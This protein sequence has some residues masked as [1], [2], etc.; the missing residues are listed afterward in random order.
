MHTRMHMHIMHITDSSSKG[1][2]EMFP[3]FRHKFAPAPCTHASMA[4][5]KFQTEQPRFRP[6]TARSK[7]WPAIVNV[8]ERETSKLDISVQKN[9]F[10]CTFW[11][12]IS[13][14]LEG[15]CV[16]EACIS[17]RLR[18]VRCC[19]ESP[20]QCWWSRRWATRFRVSQSCHPK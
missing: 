12:W 6:P 3:L 7:F 11:E 17:K 10:I 2:Y 1:V 16:V 13:D 15:S 20:R 9:N 8:W 4:P 19:L 14:M 5:S 18:V